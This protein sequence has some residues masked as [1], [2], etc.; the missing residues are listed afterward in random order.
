M[1]E[2][3][4]GDGHLDKRSICDADIQQRP[5]MSGWQHPNPQATSTAQ[6]AIILRQCVFPSTTILYQGILK[7]RCK[8]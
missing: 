2:T 6:P 8:L 4:I 3:K 5:P 1:N 7:L